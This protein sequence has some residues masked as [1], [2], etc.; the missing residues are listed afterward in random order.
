M[1]ILTI[2]VNFDK[3]GECVLEAKNGKK[4]RLTNKISPPYTIYESRTDFGKA[5]RRR[6]RQLNG[7][8]TT[9]RNKEHKEYLPL[10]VNKS[11]CL[12]TSLNEL[13]YILD[14]NYIYRSS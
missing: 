7:K 6:I 11:N 2:D 12:L 3:N 14:S 5:E 8:D 10:N 13:D 9:P 1:K 4:I